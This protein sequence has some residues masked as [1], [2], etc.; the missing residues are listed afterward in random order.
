MDVPTTIEQVDENEI[1]PEQTSAKTNF[2][3]FMITGSTNFKPTTT[4][5]AQEA[6][7]ILNLALS[8][9]FVQERLPEFIK[10]REGAP[11]DGKH[12][13]EVSVVYAAEL[14]K[15][16]KGMRIHFHA[17]VE[18]EHRVKLYIE[19]S[20]LRDMIE[21]ELLQVGPL[22]SGV[23]LHMYGIYVTGQ[24]RGASNY[25]R[26]QAPVELSKQTTH[27]FF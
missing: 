17:D 4:E 25:V 27:Q 12:I 14:G 10:D 26:K 18:I 23:Q 8:K 5:E 19:R 3:S 9:V 24:G 7:E 2:S 22:S 20:F 11:W 6:G 16:P 21:A 15:K 1:I 13:F